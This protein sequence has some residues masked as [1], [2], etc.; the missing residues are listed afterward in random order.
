MIS[1][2]K[3]LEKAKEVITNMKGLDSLFYGKPMIDWLDFET[4]KEGETEKDFILKSS[5][6]ANMFDILEK[7]SFEIHVNKETG[8]LDDFKRL[9]D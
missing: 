4:V 5:Y 8:E 1:L 9:E 7:I 6:R 3:A 2:E